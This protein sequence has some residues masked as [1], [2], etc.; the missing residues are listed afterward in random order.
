MQIRHSDICLELR[1]GK[2]NCVWGA[3]WLQIV[4]L[5]LLIMISVY[6][7]NVWLVTAWLKYY[8]SGTKHSLLST[9]EKSK[10]L[11]VFCLSSNKHQFSRSLMTITTCRTFVVNFCHHLGWTEKV[12][13]GLC[14]QLKIQVW[15][16]LTQVGFLHLSLGRGQWHCS[17]WTAF[18]VLAELLVFLQNC[19]ICLHVSWLVWSL[20]HCGQCCIVVY[21]VMHPKSFQVNP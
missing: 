18:C 6:I 7:M 12:N 8:L 14:F 20:R 11:A 4:N 9:C 15:V 1:S 21:R 19:S 2:W 13:S 10:L 16:P 5:S 3:L 17:W